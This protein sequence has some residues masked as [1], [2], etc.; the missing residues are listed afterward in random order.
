MEITFIVKDWHIVASVVCVG[1]MA[2]SNILSLV[3]HYLKR[4]LDRI[5]NDLKE[6]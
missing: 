4:K 6:I 3:Q 1:V 2:A 5:I